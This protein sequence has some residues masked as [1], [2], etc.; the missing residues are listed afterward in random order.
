MAHD[1][2]RRGPISPYEQLLDMLAREKRY[3]NDNLEREICLYSY[4]A[5]TLTSEDNIQVAVQPGYFKIFK[6]KLDRWWEGLKNDNAQ[7]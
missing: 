1:T 4:W 7:H 2:R 6:E 3:K 5:V